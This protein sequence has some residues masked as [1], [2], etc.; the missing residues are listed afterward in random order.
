MAVYS[1]GDKYPGKMFSLYVEMTDEMNQLAS[2]FLQ[3]E[4]VND[5]NQVDNY[6][7]M[8]LVQLYCCVHIVNS[9]VQ[10]SS[11]DCLSQLKETTACNDFG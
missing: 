10:S 9:Q 8:V 6:I 2:G 1:Q 5:N 3:L 4:A 11:C 7:S